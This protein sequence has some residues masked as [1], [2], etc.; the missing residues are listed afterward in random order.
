[1]A[2]PA[3]LVFMIDVDNTLL[4]ND[5]FFAE[6][7][8][9]L[10]RL[11]GEDGRQRYWRL[12]ENRRETLGYADYLGALQDLRLENGD[13]T[14]LLEASEFLLDYPFPDLLYPNALATVDHLGSM[15]T[16][17]ILSDGDIVFQPRKI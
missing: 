8:A 12:Y 1:M 10:D 2:D 5:R 13:E 17:I 6:L 16:A 9:Q 3:E 11:F 7:T 4:D 15:G 14:A